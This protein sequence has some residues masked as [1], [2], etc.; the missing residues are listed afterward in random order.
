MAI[1]GW[2]DMVKAMKK[3]PLT[4]LKDDLSKY[5]RL[6]EKEQIVVTR[7]GRPAGILVGFASKDDWFDYQLENDPR[8]LKRIEQSRKSLRNGKGVKLEDVA[9]A[10]K[11]R[12][13]R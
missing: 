12:K 3:V 2:K 11:R 6:A 7:H 8:F 10:K 1:H 9:M 5:L 4:E 13:N